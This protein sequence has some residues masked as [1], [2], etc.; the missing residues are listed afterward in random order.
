MSNMAR[1]TSFQALQQLIHSSHMHD[2]FFSN[3]EARFW[4]NVHLT[5]SQYDGDVENVLGCMAR[6]E[7][8][9]KEC[10]QQTASRCPSRH[11][12]HDGF[13]KWFTENEDYFVRKLSQTAV[14][15][16]ILFDHTFKMASNIGYWR[17]DGKWV[18]QY[19]STF[20]AMNEHGQVVTWRFTKGTS[21]EQFNPQLEQLQQ[22]LLYQGKAIKEV[23]VDNCCNLRF[24]IKQLFGQETKVTLDLFH[25]KARI[26]KTLL[27]GHTHY[28]QCLANFQHVFREDDD[29]GEKRLKCTPTIESM[30]KKIQSFTSKWKDVEDES[31]RKLFMQKTLPQLDSLSLHITKGCLSE[32]KPH[33]G[34]NQNEALHRYLNHYFT[35]P[36]MG[37]DLAYA[38]VMVLIVLYMIVIAR[39]PSPFFKQ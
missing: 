3:F 29:L 19:D 17:T 20:F 18:S 16:Y 39:Q 5:Y 21:F 2:C 9:I 15:K 6:V 35:L 33:R 38:L 31:G 24:K 12:L 23:A 36:K 4:A 7:E 28:Y 10:R 13:L 37:V 14:D 1:G 32:I 25:A 30:L 34:T 8:L 22:R 11:I 27:K 26:V